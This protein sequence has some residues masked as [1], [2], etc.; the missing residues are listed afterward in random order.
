MKDLQFDQ[1]PTKDE[2]L[3][4]A[5]CAKEIASLDQASVWFR[6]A[7]LGE[8]VLVR[9]VFGKPSYWIV[10]LHQNDQVG[11]FVRVMQDG[12]VSAI[13]QFGDNLENQNDL[14]TTVTGINNEEAMLRANELIVKGE[15][16]SEPMFVHDGPPGREAWLITTFIAGKA[17]RWIFV[18][19]GFTYARLAGELLDTSIE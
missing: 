15:T 12:N 6:I 2:A 4:A 7:M 19:P 10:P 8:P 1:F 14:P 3:R 11:G 16:V 5:S 18:T 13:G 9:T 17:G